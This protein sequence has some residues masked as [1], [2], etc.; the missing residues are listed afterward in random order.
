MSKINGRVSTELPTYLF[1]K[2][3]TLYHGFSYSLAG[4]LNTQWRRANAPVF[5]SLSMT[6]HLL[7]NNFCMQKLLHTKDEKHNAWT[8]HRTL[9]GSQG[10][11]CSRRSS[12]EP[13]AKSKRGRKTK[14]TTARVVFFACDCATKSHNE[15]HPLKHSPFFLNYDP[16]H[17]LY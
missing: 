4:Q 17:N 10:T 6:A 1:N 13:S 3:F 9:R 8:S 11:A 16:I 12:H 7:A 14:K 5:I 2:S 15:F